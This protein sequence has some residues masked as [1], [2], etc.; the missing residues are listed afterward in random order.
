MTCKQQILYLKEA[1]QKLNSKIINFNSVF[2]FPYKHLLSELNI[3]WKDSNAL[4]VRRTQ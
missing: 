3:G 4:Q 1:E 2:T